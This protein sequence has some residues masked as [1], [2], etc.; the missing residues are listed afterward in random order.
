MEEAKVN[1]QKEINKGRQRHGTDGKA[2]KD[3]RRPKKE[4]HV[5]LQTVF[6]M[7]HHFTEFQSAAE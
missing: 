1:R 3:G 7:F 4:R 2:K 5:G 6:K